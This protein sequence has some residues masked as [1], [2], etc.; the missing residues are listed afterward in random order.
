MAALCEPH[1]KDMDPLIKRLSSAYEHLGADLSGG[2]ALGVASDGAATTGG[3]TE[4]LLE[5]APFV[6]VPIEGNLS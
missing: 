5:F 6:S 3:G 1:G 4:G 2:S